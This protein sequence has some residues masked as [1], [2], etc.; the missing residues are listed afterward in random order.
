MAAHLL[1]DIRVV[2]KVNMPNYHPFSCDWQAGSH[3]AM[4]SDPSTEFGQQRLKLGLI[5]FPM[6]DV[7]AR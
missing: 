6:S 5:M 3:W 2:V 4:H 7:F 1:F